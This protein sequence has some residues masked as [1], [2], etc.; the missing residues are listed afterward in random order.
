MLSLETLGPAVQCCNITLCTE[1]LG[2]AVRFL[3]LL[4]ARMRTIVVSGTHLSRTVERETERYMA[5]ILRF[6]VLDVDNEGVG[7]GSKLQSGLQP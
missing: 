6:N 4:V 1:V 7:L 3:G 2:C 5:Y